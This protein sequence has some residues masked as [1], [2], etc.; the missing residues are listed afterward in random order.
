MAHARSRPLNEV[1]TPQHGIAVRTEDIIQRIVRG[2][3]SIAN[4]MGTHVATLHRER[5]ASGRKTLHS[6]HAIH[7]YGG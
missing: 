5:E 2:D 6:G 3:I 7:S 1:L 4:F